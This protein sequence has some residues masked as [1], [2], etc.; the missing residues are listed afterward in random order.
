ML[1]Q[2]TSA[3]DRVVRDQHDDRTDDRHAHAPEVEARHSSSAKEVE[4][5]AAHQGADDAERDVR[6]RPGAS[7]T[8]DPAGDEPGN[9]TQ[10][11]DATI[12]IRRASLSRMP[13]S[14]KR[15]VASQTSLDKDWGGST[16]IP[17]KP[18]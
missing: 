14:T 9:Q 3:R 15:A 6:K 11:I 7:T 8:D 13:T 4:E 5:S 17:H 16:D 1:G 18:G 2:W 12:D 10:M